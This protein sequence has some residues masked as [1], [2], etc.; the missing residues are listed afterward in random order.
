MQDL[1][2]KVLAVLNIVRC[3]DNHSQ[4]L[5]VRTKTA[6]RILPVLCAVVGLAA[7]ALDFTPEPVEPTDN[8]EDVSKFSIEVCTAAVEGP[9]AVQKLTSIVVP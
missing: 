1:V 5:A 9:E 2:G 6:M 7:G 8:C 3:P 4:L